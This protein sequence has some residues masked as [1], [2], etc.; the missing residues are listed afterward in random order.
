MNDNNNENSHKRTVDELEVDIKDEEEVDS[1]NHHNLESD[2]VQS[3]QNDGSEPP[4]KKVRP[5]EELDIRFLVSSK[6]CLNL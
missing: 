3:D 2:D 1:N 6:V 5:T 4:A